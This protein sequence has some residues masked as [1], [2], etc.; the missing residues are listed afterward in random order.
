MEHPEGGA[1]KATPYLGLR[2]FRR[3][4]APL[5]FGRTVE[6]LQFF[7]LVTNAE[8]RIILLYGNTGVGKSSFLAAGV[9]PRLEMQNRSPYYARR[10]KVTGLDKQLASLR[11]QHN[12]NPQPPVYILDQVEEMFTDPVP[13]EPERFKRELSQTLKDDKRATLVLG[14][15]SDYL[16]EMNEL[17]R[18][19]LLRQE[20]L[21]LLALEQSALVEAVEGVWKDPVLRRAFDLELEPGFA[22]AVALDLLRTETGSAASILQNRLLKLYENAYKKRRTPENPTVKL[23]TA[24]YQALIQANSAEEELLDYQLQRLRAETQASPDEKLLLETL[25]VFV[26]DK[27][28]AGTVLLTELPEDRLALHQALRRVNLLAELREPDKALRLSHDLLAP[29]VRRRYDTFVKVENLGLKQENL[30]L[31]LR[32]IRTN[33]PELKFEEAAA[34]LQQSMALGIHPELRA[35][36]AFE[37]AYV[38]L[39][40]D[41]QDRGDMLAALYGQIEREAK[42]IL[43]PLPSNDR[44]NW[45]RHCDPAHFARLETRYFPEMRPVPG[46][47]FVMGDAERNNETVHKQEISNFEIGATPVTWQQYGLYCFA[48]N[49]DLPHDEGWGRADRPAVNVSWYDA[50]EYANWLNR[51]LG[52]P[53]VYDIDKERE[54]PNNKS[55]YDK[56]KW[57]VSPRSGAKGFRLPTEAEWEYAAREGGRV[58]RFGNGKNIADPAEINFNASVNYKKPYSVAGQ[59]RSQTTPVKQFHSNALGLYDMSGNVWEWCQDWLGDYPE[60]PEKDYAGSEGGSDR[61][62]RGGS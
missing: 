14:F 17:L 46:G 13:D 27:P 44:L 6:M 47:V 36:I 2:Y 23:L 50:V 52:L 43:P 59:F 24:D 33:L 18:K 4:D 21:P 29:V 41:K 49:L 28:T 9:R 38:Y 19:V 51:R 60:N 45:L 10:N 39:Q 32:Q 8:V 55:E 16:L 48:Q 7:D 11:T 20:D 1:H 26:L 58:V 54:D 37:L 56:L 40:T 57:T 15:R 30:E 34:D 35:P 3:K 25:N 61:V 31:L 62:V 5:F 12:S 22:E 53:P 42:K